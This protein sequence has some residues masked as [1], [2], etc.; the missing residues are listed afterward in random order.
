MNNNEIDDMVNVSQKSDGVEL[1][2]SKDIPNEVVQEQVA[3]CQAETCSC[4]T[5]V[6][7][8]KVESFTSTSTEEGIKVKITGNITAEQV[9]ENVLSCAP[10]LAEK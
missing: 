8:E 6:F 2:F 1:K 7:R 3:S 4:C 9:E 10:K 5:P